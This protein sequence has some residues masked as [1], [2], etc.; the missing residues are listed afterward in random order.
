MTPKQLLPALAMLV[1]ALPAV[2][3]SRT[4][5]GTPPTGFRAEIVAG[6]NETSGKLLQLAEAI[7]AG[8][9]DWRPAEGVRSTG[10]VFAHIAAANYLILESVG[11]RPPDGTRPHAMEKEL[12]GKDEIVAALRKSAAFIRQSIRNLPDAD[13]DRP[14]K[15]FGGDSTVRAALLM[16]QT[17]ESEHLGQLIAYARMNG[18]TPPWSAAQEP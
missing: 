6:L 12:R 1:I 11:V 17:H 7:P 8:E 14:V 5:S 13:L 4:T 16:A 2:A 10:E 15:L 3:Q 18:I 9:Y